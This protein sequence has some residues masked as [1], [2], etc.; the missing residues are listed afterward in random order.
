[1]RVQPLVLLPLWLLTA[2]DPAPAPADS[3]T[4]GEDTGAPADAG[5]LEDAGPPG[6]AGI[7]PGYLMVGPA[8]RPARLQVPPAHDGTTALPL[9]VLLHGYGVSASLQDLYF[10]MS[11]VA[12]DVGAYLLLP[13]GTMDP[14]GNRFWNSGGP[15]CD[16]GGTGVDDVGYL[17]GLLDT[18]EATVPVD[19][20]RVYF[21]GH[22]NGAFM[23]Y[24]M[25]CEI[26]DRV[27]GVAALAGTEGTMPECF[28]TR[29]VSVLHLHGTADA[30]VAYSGGTIME[31]AYIA[32]E[33]A[34]LAW[35]MRDGCDRMAVDGGRADLD[36]TIAGEET[37]ITQYPTCE[38][39]SAVELWTMEGS[40]HIP[41]LAAGTTRR[42]I[43][44]L[45]A[46]TR[47]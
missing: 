24:R 18:V 9:V 40:G 13:D 5:A 19:T 47:L 3:G 1:M 7:V 32:A 14:G 34:V 2:C 44:W 42:M 8:E 21:V 41:P 10:G 16:F 27:T 33:D 22:S 17:T 31:G 45:F 39:G 26:A 46:R 15:C 43:D 23:S 12:R 36:T 35:L 29:P 37:V 30:T 38:G 28:P 20:A 4:A 25:A 11:R 6:D